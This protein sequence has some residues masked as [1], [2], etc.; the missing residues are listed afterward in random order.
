MLL[1]HGYRLLCSMQRCRGR[2]SRQGPRGAAL[3]L[4]LHLRSARLSRCAR[5]THGPMGC[6]C[7]GSGGGCLVLLMLLLQCDLR[8]CDLLLLPGLGCELRLR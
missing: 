1:L 5:G 3:L 7:G 2:A 4:L 8:R 6:S